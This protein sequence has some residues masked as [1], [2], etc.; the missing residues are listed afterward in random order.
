MRLSR[1][2]DLIAAGARADRVSG[3]PVRPV[4]FERQQSDKFPSI[5]LLPD[6]R[7]RFWPLQLIEAALQ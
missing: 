4:E 1:S 5:R 3:L 2:R 7:V 6:C